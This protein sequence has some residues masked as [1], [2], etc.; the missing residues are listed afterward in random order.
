MNAH[1]HW[2]TIALAVKKWVR[3]DL[4]SDVRLGLV[5]FNEGAHLAH[6]VAELAADKI[7]EGVEVHITNR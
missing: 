4:P 5:L 6:S 3:H 1:G 2:D 7:R